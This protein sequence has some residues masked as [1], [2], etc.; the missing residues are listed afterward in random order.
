[1]IAQ[2]EKQLVDSDQVIR[3]RKIR[4]RPTIL[5]LVVLFSLAV[6]WD[7]F[8]LGIHVRLLIWFAPIISFWVNRMSGNAPAWRP[9]TSRPV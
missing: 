8:L 5:T 7:W 1:M 4:T 2:E 9:L 3:F 6:P